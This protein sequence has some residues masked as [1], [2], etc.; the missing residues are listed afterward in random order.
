M[1]TVVKKNVLLYTFY[2][3]HAIVN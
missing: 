2:R 1:S 3:T